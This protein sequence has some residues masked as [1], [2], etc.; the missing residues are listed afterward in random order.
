MTNFTVAYVDG[1]GDEHKTII[2]AVDTRAAIKEA[3]LKCPDAV[4][5]VLAQPN[6]PDLNEPSY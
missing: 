1:Q 4:R 5:V 3:L 6:P 2:T